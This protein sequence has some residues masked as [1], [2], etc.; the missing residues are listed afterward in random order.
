[1]VNWVRS[2]HPSNVIA[3]SLLLSGSYFPKHLFIISHQFPWSPLTW[4]TN[5][6]YA[7]T[8]AQHIQLGTLCHGKNIREVPG[9]CRGPIPGSMPESVKKSILCDFTNAVWDHQSISLKKKKIPDLELEK[10]LLLTLHPNSILCD[11]S[12][13][14]YYL[15]WLCHWVRESMTWDKECE[16][17][18][19]TWNPLLNLLVVFSPNLRPGYLW[20]LRGG[21]G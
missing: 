2:K 14:P 13:V 7:G 20:K 15:P 16:M 18:C 12:Q 21:K 11:F 19:H 10:P 17:V 8:R 4:I 3:E 1:M 9:I 6:L 5:Q